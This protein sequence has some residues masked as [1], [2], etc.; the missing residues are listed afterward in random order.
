[1][2]KINQPCLALASKLS[3][4]TFQNDMINFQTFCFQKTFIQGPPITLFSLL[5]V[6]QAPHEIGCVLAAAATGSIPP[7]GSLLH[8][9][10]SFS[11]LP[12]PVQT[13]GC[14]VK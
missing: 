10:P 14:A 4:L 9:I 3:V 7:C 1:M 13:F 2:K 5:S 12:F 11:P 8:V 6:G